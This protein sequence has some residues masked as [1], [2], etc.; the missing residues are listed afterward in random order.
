MKN[1]TLWS[2]KSIGKKDQQF[3]F[4]AN[5]SADSITEAEDNF[6][7][8]MTDHSTDYLITQTL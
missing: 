4:V 6:Q 1:Y 7:S 3:F 5:T 2:V 8:D